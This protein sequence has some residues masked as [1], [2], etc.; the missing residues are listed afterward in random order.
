MN[1][2]KSAFGKIIGSVDLALH[3]FLCL[4]PSLSLVCCST[5]HMISLLWEMLLYHFSYLYFWGI[6]NVRNVAENNYITQKT[7]LQAKGFHLNHYPD[8]GLQPFE[9]SIINKKNVRLIVKYLASTSRTLPN[10]FRVQNK[11]PLDFITI[12][13]KRFT[14]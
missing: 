1:K 13:K 5:F 14:F 9:L 6:D 11:L 8:T 4:Y 12:N 10:F 7:A 2:G 3:P